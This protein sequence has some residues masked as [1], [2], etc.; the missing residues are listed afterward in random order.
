MVQPA[1]SASEQALTNF[2]KKVGLLASHNFVNTPEEIQAVITSNTVGVPSNNKDFLDHAFDSNIRGYISETFSGVLLN[3]VKNTNSFLRSN[4]D[5]E[6]GRINGMYNQIKSNIYKTR[7]SVL[8]KL[9]VVELNRFRIKIIQGTIFLC[10][11]C[12]SILGLLELQ[13]ISRNLGII[14]ICILII[15]YIVLIIAALRVNERRRIDDWDKYYFSR[16]N[17]KK[18]KNT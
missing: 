1:N 13:K 2:N 15:I 17:Q 14:I 16:P 9:Y 10:I 8:E 12:F 6:M 5:D 3:N 18:S 7:I 11:L 4:L